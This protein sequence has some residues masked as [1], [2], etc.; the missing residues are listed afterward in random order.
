MEGILENDSRLKHFKNNPIIFERN[1]INQLQ[2]KV[3]NIFP[4]NRTQR[5][6]AG[7]AHSFTICQLAE[8]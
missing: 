1:F 7:E 6:R 3:T 4:H 8:Y 5:L 2:K